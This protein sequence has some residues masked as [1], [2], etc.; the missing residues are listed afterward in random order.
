MLSQFE[1]LIDIIF[2]NLNVKDLELNQLKDRLITNELYDKIT[3]CHSL[4]VVKFIGIKGL[5]NQLEAIETNHKV[6][7]WVLSIKSGEITRK[8]V[9]RIQTILLNTNESLVYVSSTN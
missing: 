7:Q 8:A 1:E 6:K 4:R 9:K 5:E 2:D 3:N